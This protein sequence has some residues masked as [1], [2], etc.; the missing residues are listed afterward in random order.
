[1]RKLPKKFQNSTLVL[2]DMVSTTIILNDIVCHPK[3]IFFLRSITFINFLEN[4]NFVFPKNV[5]Y[6]NNFDI[7]GSIA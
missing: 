6:F 2:V 1:M 4:K 5:S 7:S 3:I